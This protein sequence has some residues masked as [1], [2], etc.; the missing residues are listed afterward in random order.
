MAIFEGEPRSAS[1]KTRTKARLIGLER[2]DLFRMMEELPA[3][4]ITVC[5]TMSRRV[6]QLTEQSVSS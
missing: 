2:K 6:R 5:R 1:V 3:I 4:A